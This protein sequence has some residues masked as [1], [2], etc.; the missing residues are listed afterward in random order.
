MS[1]ANQQTFIAAA[2]NPASRALG[3]GN[4]RQNR[5]HYRVT[6]GPEWLSKKVSAGENSWCRQP[7]YFGSV[8]K[9]RRYPL[10]SA[11]KSMKY[12]S[13]VSKQGVRV[14]GD[15]YGREILSS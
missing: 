8:T 1:E 9:V 13:N 12:V 4:I 15:L 2:M 10:F 5:T 3:M 14:G 6:G 11:T 7:N